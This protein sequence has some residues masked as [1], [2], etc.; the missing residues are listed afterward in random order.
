MAKRQ[1]GK[2]TKRGDG[3]CDGRDAPGGRAVVGTIGWGTGAPSP[4][5]WFSDRA[6]LYITTHDRDE[7][8]RAI[9]VGGEAVAAIEQSAS[10]YRCPSRDRLVELVASKFAL[11]MDTCRNDRA[12]EAEVGAAAVALAAAAWRV[13]YRV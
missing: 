2:A 3:R 6:T 7:V 10:L 5:T 12:S 11:L 9:E 4:L 13:R 8:S 1:S